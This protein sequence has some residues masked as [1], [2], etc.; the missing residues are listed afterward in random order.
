MF[1]ELNLIYQSTILVLYFFVT[2][3]FI[4]EIVLSS[5]DLVPG[6]TILLPATGKT[7]PPKKYVR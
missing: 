2:L 3:N 4:L 5:V 1:S 6:D 7:T